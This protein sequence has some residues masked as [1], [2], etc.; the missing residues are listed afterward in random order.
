MSSH[1]DG[2]SPSR[3]SGTSFYLHVTVNKTAL[4]LE[5]RLTVPAAITAAVGSGLVWLLID[6]IRST[7]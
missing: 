1:F 7:T 6:F 2:R 4:R 3:D 5:L